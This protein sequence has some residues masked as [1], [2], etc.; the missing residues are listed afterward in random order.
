MTWWPVMLLLIGAPFVVHGWHWL[1]QQRVQH[2]H[3]T[4]LSRVRDTA[5]QER[6]KAYADGRLDGIA[7][8]RTSELA[9]V[10]KTRR[11]LQE[12]EYELEKARSEAAPPVTPAEL[13]ALC[14][15]S[16]S[17]RERRALK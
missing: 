17:C 6:N 7:E 8:V 2:A 11:A 14:K 15:A 4:E 12:L 16:A 9:E 3:A 1:D 5:L 10:E 13:L